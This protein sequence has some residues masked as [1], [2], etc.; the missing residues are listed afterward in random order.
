MIETALAWDQE[1]TD[2]HG[3][4]APRF[5]RSEPRERAFG[6]LRGLLSEV[7][8]KNGWQMAEALGEATPYGTQRLLN[9]SQWGAD[10]VRDDLREYAVEHLGTDDGVLVIDETGFIKKGTE[11]VGVKR[12]YTG[13][14]GK[15]D[16]CQIGVFLCQATEAGTA[17][18]D[19]ELY[20][21]K[22]WAANPERRRKAGVPG[23]VKFATKPKL[24]QQM[25]ERAFSEGVPRR[26]VTGDSVYGS[27]RTL[28]RWL[29]EKRQPFV[30]AVPSNESL[31]AGPIWEDGQVQTAAEIAYRLPSEAFQRLSAGRGSK[32]ERLY[33]WALTPLWRLQ[34]TDEERAWSHAL[35]IRRSTEDPEEA[36]YYVVFA[37]RGE[38]SLET[39]VGVAGMR[40]RIEE[41]FE[42]AKDVCGLDEYEVRKYEAWHR[43]ITLSLLAH[44]FLAAVA[45]REQKKGIQQTTG[46]SKTK[47]KSSFR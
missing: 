3:H 7:K 32:G 4:I 13:T 8:R 37:P 6:Y 31:W 39:V 40:W 47:S 5:A 26:W 30:L 44:A 22:E 17:F 15:I 35:L 33:E 14:T 45:A 42:Q 18:L 9:G 43:H 12:Q 16:N 25:L 34:L 38:A 2:L 20:L 1:L 27:S 21:P 28:R 24:A 29:E 10:A 11:S 23:E 36:A 19:R 41:G 46:T